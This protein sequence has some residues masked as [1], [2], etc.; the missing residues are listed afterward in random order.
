MKPL[1]LLDVTQAYLT[2]GVAVAEIPEMPYC[3]VK[4]KNDNVWSV[5]E[6]TSAVNATE[7]ERL[8]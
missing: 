5:F 4:L 1:H 3:T 7:K 6:I 2:Y 8:G